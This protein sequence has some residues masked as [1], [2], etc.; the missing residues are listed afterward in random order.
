MFVLKTLFYCL[1]LASLVVAPLPPPPSPG[2]D[3]CG[4]FDHTNDAGFSTCT[5]S[6]IP[7][8]PSPYGIVC[9]KDS[10][11]TLAVKTGRCAI[12][13]QGMCIAL[14]KGELSA[15]EWHWTGDASATPCRVGVFLAAGDSVAPLPS[16][17]RC[18]NQIFQPLV[19]SCLNSRYNIGTV[20]LK[21][22]PDYTKN[23]SGLAVNPGYHSYVMAPTA[24]FYSTFPEATPGVFGSP[25]Y[26]IAGL[27]NGS[28][29]DGLRA[30]QEVSHGRT[31]N[32]G[33]GQSGV[34]TQ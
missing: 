9:G 23:F 18:L 34:A 5:A 3:P 28:A 17:K 29:A 27:G 8:G 22:L 16:Y 12:S 1:H 25:L 14:A 32:T 6:V 4:P 30:V 20:N 31:P 11:I 10:D 7:G 19:F 15:G 21:Q 24:L 26:G 13:A 2:T 33:Q